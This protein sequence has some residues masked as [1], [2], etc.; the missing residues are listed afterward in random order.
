MLLKQSQLSTNLKN[1]VYISDHGKESE[2]L[3]F[4]PMEKEK[5]DIKSLPFPVNQHAQLFE[6]MKE[7]RPYKSWALIHSRSP[8]RVYLSGGMAII[9]VRLSFG[10]ITNRFVE[11]MANVPNAENVYNI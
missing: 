8:K 7:I 5:L 9:Q 1:K 4:C 2:C 6:K 3:L 10:L 11:D